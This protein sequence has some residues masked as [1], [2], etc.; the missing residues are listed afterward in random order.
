MVFPL[1]FG[2]KL[3]G[4]LGAS[5]HYVNKIML[6]NHISNERTSGSAGT[7]DNQV[8]YESKTSFSYAQL[9][10]SQY[11]AEKSWARTE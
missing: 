2:V 1:F 11:P 10:D 7:M 9:D 8:E 5:P 3:T 4:G 6:K